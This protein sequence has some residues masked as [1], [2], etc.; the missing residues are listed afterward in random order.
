VEAHSAI[1]H[2]GHHADAATY[3]NRN[4]VAIKADYDALRSRTAFPYIILLSQTSTELLLMKQA[5]E[6]RVKFL[7]GHKAMSLEDREKGL[8]VNFEN[9]E[10]I[11]AEYVVGADGSKSTVSAS[12]SSF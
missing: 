3:F 5:E 9:G 12:D 2:Y 7:W 8:T 10:S 6:A 1:D 4:D 11:T